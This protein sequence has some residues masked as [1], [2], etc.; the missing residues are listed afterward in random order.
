MQMS[1]LHHHVSAGCIDSVL[2][3][4]VRLGVNSFPPSLCDSYLLTFRYSHGYHQQEIGLWSLKRTLADKLTTRSQNQTHR[5][6]LFGW[7]CFQLRGLA[8][9]LIFFITAAFEGQ[10]NSSSKNS[11]KETDGCLDYTSVQLRWQ[12]LEIRVMLSTQTTGHLREM[13]SL[14]N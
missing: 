8:V 13:G 14:K 11:I 10:T 4:T 9:F 7:R 1:A 2:R 12:I 3:A 5:H 6:E